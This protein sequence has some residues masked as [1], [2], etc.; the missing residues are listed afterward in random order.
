MPHSLAAKPDAPLIYACTY[1][2]ENRGNDIKAVPVDDEPETLEPAGYKT[3]IRW[4]EAED[5]WSSEKSKGMRIRVRRLSDLDIPGCELVAGIGDIDP[6]THYTLHYH[7][8]VELYYI[9]AGEGI[10]LVDGDEVNVRKGSVIYINGGVVHGADNR[11]TEPITVYYVYG[12]EN[13]GPAM[14]WTAV[15]EVYGRPRP[16]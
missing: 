4:D 2:T 6:D 16:R 12:T 1:G 5:Y 13:S 10:V 14:N 3:W 8:Q 11:G 15:E 7:D 9:P